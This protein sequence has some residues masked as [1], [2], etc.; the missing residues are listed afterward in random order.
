MQLY[1][2][3][4][5]KLG[6]IRV[7]DLPDQL[8]KRVRLAGWLIT[9]KVVA[10]RHGEPMQF[11]TFEDETGVVETT[12]FPR[13]YRRFCHMLDRQR[14]YLLTGKVEEDWGAITLTVDGVEMLR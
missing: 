8:G 11:L 14:P 10:T 12:F 7:C 3:I 2:R 13:P 1:A 6:T 9:G 5:Q 4:L